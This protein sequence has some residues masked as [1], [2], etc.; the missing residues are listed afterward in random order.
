VGGAGTAGIALFYL[1][2]EP[3]AKVAPDMLVGPG[4]E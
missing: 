2:L 1:R 3:G 4:G